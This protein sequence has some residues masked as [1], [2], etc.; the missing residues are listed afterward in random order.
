M[1]NLS[2][3][4][5]FLI[6]VSI[7]F[8]IK[9]MAKFRK[10][11]ADRSLV[12]FLLIV[13]FWLCVLVIISFPSFAHLLSIKLGMGENFNTLIFTVFIINF[14]IIIKL[15]ASIENLEHDIT[16]LVRER[17][18]SELPKY[19]KNKSKTTA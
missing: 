19:Y 10:N 9:N 13:V 17:A 16:E 12:R 4:Q 3:Y 11:L 15:L 5:L 7:F 18:L 8:L 2:F 6:T 1:F 14:I